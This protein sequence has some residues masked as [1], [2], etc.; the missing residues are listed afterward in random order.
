MG[1]TFNTIREKDTVTSGILFIHPNSEELFPDSKV[2]FNI[3][4]NLCKVY[5]LKF[6]QVIIDRLIDLTKFDIENGAVNR[7]F[8]YELSH[9]FCEPLEFNDIS[10][11]IDSFNPNQ[12]DNI[13]AFWFHN[14]RMLDPHQKSLALAGCTELPTASFDIN[15]PINRKPKPPKDLYVPTEPMVR[16]QQCAVCDC[17]LTAEDTDPH[18]CNK[19]LTAIMGHKHEL[20]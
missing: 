7:F 8:S 20:I 5:E 14:R 13:S 18:L 9:G 2:L 15:C 3:V 19:C 16:F 12:L 11:K 1:F 6:S 10:V 17:N 4:D